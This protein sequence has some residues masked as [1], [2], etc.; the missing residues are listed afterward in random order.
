LEENIALDL[1]LLFMLSFAT[2]M[3]RE[4]TEFMEKTKGGGCDILADIL[5]KHNICRSREEGRMAIAPTLIAH[6]ILDKFPPG[7]SPPPPPPSPSAKP[8]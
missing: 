1:F 3:Q 4:L 2:H 7:Y 8:H 6:G 5:V